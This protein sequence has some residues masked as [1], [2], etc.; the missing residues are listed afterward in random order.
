MESAN[1]RK[2]F[3]STLENLATDYQGSLFLTRRRGM[4]P[5]VILLVGLDMQVMTVD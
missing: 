3:Y 5:A 2:L 4:S 1:I